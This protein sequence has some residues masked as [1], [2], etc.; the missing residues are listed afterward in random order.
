MLPVNNIII[1]TVE[2]GISL[3]N[4]EY[5]FRGGIPFF[6][7]KRKIRYN[8]AYQI[9]NLNNNAAE[10]M[11]KRGMIRTDSIQHFPFFYLW[12]IA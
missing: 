12:D 6:K 5:I 1:I 10:I 11:A 2:A 3:K 4:E 8:L 9:Y 7:L